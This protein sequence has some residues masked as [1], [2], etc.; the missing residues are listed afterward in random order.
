MYAL[1]GS[2]DD[3]V[4]GQILHVQK[5]KPVGLLPVLVALAVMGCSH[6]R[7]MC[8][9]NVEDVGPTVET[10]YRYC[11]VDEQLK[12][13]LVRFAALK[14]AYPKVFADDGI[15]FTAT[16]PQA[17]EGGGGDYGM[18]KS[19][20]GWTGVF[21]YALSLLTLPA[22]QTHEWD[23]HY[24]VDLVDMPDAHAEFSTCYRLDSAFA[25]W[26]PSPLLFYVSSVG[27]LGDESEYENARR[28]SCH[29]VQ[30][31]SD[32]V[33][34]EIK[35]HPYGANPAYAYGLAVSLKKIEDAGLVDAWRS[36]HR[37]LGTDEKTTLGADIE[38]LEFGR[39]SGSDF[40]YR[41]KLR[42]QKG[43][44]SLR[45]AREVRKTLVKMIRSDYTTSNPYASATM[46]IVDFPV[47]D[48]RRAEV[49]GRAI[50]LQL[51]IRTLDYEPIARRGVMKIR[52]GETQLA[53]A[54][55][56]LRRNIETIVRDKGVA[57]EAGKLPTAATFRILDE[58]MSDGVLEVAFTA[59]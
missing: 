7:V 8:A 58:K 48:L 49:S 54:R 43:D 27:D 52:L 47:Y 46:L 2:S 5:V 32:D 12:N 36:K 55:N 16:M 57:L 28:F 19:S 51:D 30:F 34:G 9:A 31:A 18:E 42:H 56:Y 24:V 21:P 13:N 25:M 38:L 11:F 44:M 39:E 17:I 4:S 40:A 37:T 10:K 45:E 29:N 22:C 33:I 50:V 14:K 26:T 59:E 35:T 53:E 15:P 41:F 20:Y 1:I 3:M 23:H 6:R